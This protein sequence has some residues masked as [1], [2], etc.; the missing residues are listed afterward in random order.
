MKRLG[1]RR[2]LL[3]SVVAG[4]LLA[5]VALIAG[6][7]IIL[8]RTLDHDARSLVRSRAASTVATLRVAH[9]RIH[10]VETPDTGLP[11]SYVWVF[12]GR[13][14]L[15]QPNAGA[16]VNRAAAS[17]TTGP[18]RFLDLAASHTR[19]YGSPVLQNGRRI[20]TVVAGLSL[21]PYDHTRRLALIASLVLGAAVLLVVS[22]AAY[23]LLGAALQP[24]V[25]MTRQ[26]AAWSERD[27][28]RRFALGEPH[29]E[30]S[31]LAATLDGLLD[32]LAASLRREQR[33]SA[34][35]S[36]ELR[37][38]LARVTAESELA[39]RREREPSEY[40]RALERINESATYL[41]RTVN[42]LLAAAR[43][44]SG[45]TR[46]TADARAVA[47]AA[48]RGCAELAAERGLR[49]RVDTAAAGFRLGLDRDLAERILQPVLENA[50]R[51]GEHDIS[52]SVACKNSSV[53]YTVEDDGAGV[54]SEE[55]E[56]IFEPGVRG[57]AARN[58][59]E[60]AGLGLALSRRLARSTGG[61]VEAQA[62]AGG[63]RFVVT[64][65]ST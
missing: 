14:T 35:L 64:L 36:H 26:A 61:D 2:R 50:C 10:L 48:V 31:E 51:Y 28:D 45:G 16:V 65:P 11:D 37:T 1:I 56:R 33:F 63:G 8:A 18:A 9:E 19:L 24:V 15:E 30:L 23:W 40:R 52:I 20:G 43:H 3:L 39:L 57:S 46:G 34:E 17:L 13:R 42:A 44:E 55:S 4:V 25:R 53:T 38:P 5:L 29:D 54:A 62:G 6:F 41:T 49:V 22:L 12:S 32:R 60:G 21:A 58:T 7:N 47:E 59:G 27:L